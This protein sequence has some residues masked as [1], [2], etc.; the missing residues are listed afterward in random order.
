MRRAQLNRE[1]NAGRQYLYNGEEN[2]SP[3]SIIISRIIKI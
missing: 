3:E 2:E 1:L